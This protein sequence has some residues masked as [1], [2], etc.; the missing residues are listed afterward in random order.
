MDPELQAAFDAHRPVLLAQAQAETLKWCPAPGELVEQRFGDQY[1]LR[2]FAT[3]T[4]LDG[5]TLGRFL[6]TFRQ[7]MFVKWDLPA[8]QSAVHAFRKSRQDDTDHAVDEL[9]STLGHCTR[10]PDVPRRGAASLIAMFAQPRSP[11]FAMSKKPCLA[12]RYRLTA[13]AN[14]DDLRDD[15]IAN[16]YPAFAAVCRRV[17]ADEQRKAD[18]A[19]CVAQLDHALGGIPGPMDNRDVCPLDFIARRF[20]DKLLWV[21]G[22]WLEGERRQRRPRRRNRRA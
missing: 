10:R 11:V 16:S 5:E 9:A 4:S 8:L 22:S 19:A 12:L 21:E 3:Q 15:A 6:W 7:R 18:F 20:L 13:A 2:Q 14:E 1:W 17:L